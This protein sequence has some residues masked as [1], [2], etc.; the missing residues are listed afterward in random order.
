MRHYSVINRQQ[1]LP[2]Y[3]MP[4]QQYRHFLLT[5]PENDWTPDLHELWGYCKGQLE[6]GEGGYRHWQVYA[7]ARRPTTVT[8]FKRNLPRTAHVEPTRSQAARDYV[9]KE[10]TRVSGTPFELGTLNIRR[11]NATDWALVRAAAQ[12]GDL[13]RIPD[14]IFVRH[15]GNLRRIAADYSRPVAIERSCEV[16]W[17]TTGTGKT[18]MA[19]EKAGLEAYAKDPCTKWWCGYS[20]QESCIIDEFRGTI[21]ISHLLRW[22]DRYPVRVEAKGSSMPLLVK[23]FYITSNLDPRL[24][25]QDVD[26]QTIDA[27]LRRIRITH[28][29]E[30]FFPTN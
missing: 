1:G 30:P 23:T 6:E 5:I 4:A 12:S 20:G 17:G 14:E 27:L 7:V 25:Y 15:Y 9:W 26:Q 11:N 8:G 3:C 19:W 21:N 29:Q 16:Y 24:W 13:V 22:L 18:R 2:N 10:N 28:F